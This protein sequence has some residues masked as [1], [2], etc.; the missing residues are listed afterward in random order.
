MGKR[1]LIVDD[2]QDILDILE[3]ILSDA[4]YE[5]TKALGGREAIVLA[6]KNH[7]DLIMLDI[8]MP[9]MD[10]SQTTDILRNYSSTRDI[11]IVYLS[12]LVHKDDV[13]EDGH[14]LGS[15]VGDM[16]FIPKTATPAD[17]LDIVQKNIKP[18][19]SSDEKI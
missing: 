9:G 14:I 5:V 2:E 4:G 12:S 11:P 1:V 7:P 19:F 6:Q 3:A 18:S 13:E 8:K 17:I 16:Y 15:R 10:G